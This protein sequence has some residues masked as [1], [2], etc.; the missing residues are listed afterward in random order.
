MSTAAGALQR[1]GRLASNLLLPVLA[2]LTA[3]AVGAVVIIFSDPT[4]LD[5]WRSFFADPGEALSGSWQVV[6]DSYRALFDSS[7]GSVQGLSETLTAATPLMLAGLSVALAFRAGLFNI[8]GE[9]Q[10]IAGSIAAGWVGF[11]FDLP[12]IV[13]LPL[14]LAAGFVGGALWGAIAGVLKAR[15]GAHEVITTIMLNFIAL[16]LL[17]YLLT[18]ESFLRPGRADP[19]SKQVADTAELPRLSDNPIYR[20]HLGFLIALAAALFVWWLLF[21]STVGFRMRAVGTNPN[22]ARY[23]GMSVGGTWVLSMALAGGLCG[24]G[25]TAQLLG[26]EHTLTGGFSGVGF[27]AIALALLGR[28][29]PL[30][31]VGAA[32]LFGV[33]RAGSVGMQ[34]A[35]STPVDIIVVIQA[36]IIVFVAA[37]SLIRAVYRIKADRV[38]GD[39]RFATGWGA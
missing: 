33:L 9:G 14:A 13:H 34:A 35:T 12:T 22:A 7:L 21:R 27:D 24:L 38:A 11:T 37:P 30:G 32:L 20:L 31:V 17:D 10:I 8:G 1:G 3:L 36:L 23:A 4:T 29:N 2:L 6:H 19:I 25:G 15:T 39:Q 16:R 26:V 28:S 18:T 5:S